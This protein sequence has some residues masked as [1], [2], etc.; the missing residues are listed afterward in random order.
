MPRWESST[1]MKIH[2]GCGGLVRWV[3]AYDQPGVGYTGECLGCSCDR[4]PVES[5][6]P[7]EIPDDE[8][9][10]ELYG[11]VEAH[12]LREFEWDPEE[13]EYDGRQA[14]FRELIA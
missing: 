13:H 1:H 8:A 5:I 11:R 10:V 12:D 14:A 3:E 2:V 9:C 7:F 4:V 6:L